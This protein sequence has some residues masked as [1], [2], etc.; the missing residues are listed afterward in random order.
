V[1]SAPLT[2]VQ[3]ALVPPGGSAVAEVSLVVPGKF[4]L[5]DHALSRMQRG[6]SGWLIVEGAPRPDLYNGVMQP[7][8]GH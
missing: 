8:S 2:D 5:V 4:I 7:G 6:L 3:T 1:T